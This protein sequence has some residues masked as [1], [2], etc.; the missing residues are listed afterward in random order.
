MPPKALAS[1]VKVGERLALFSYYRVD[2]VDGSFVNVTDEDGNQVRVGREIVDS[3]M[4][5]TTQFA[6]TTKVGQTRMAQIIEGLGQLP[7]CVCF[8]KKV[9][10]NA[11]ADGLDGADLSSQAKRRKLLKTLM[12]GE[13]RVMH[14]R[15]HRSTEDDVEMEL[16]RYKV[17]DLEAS[18]PGKPA[19]RL[20]D[21]RTVKWLIVDGVKFTV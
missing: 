15:L 2:S 6:K 13:E 5:S 9:D 11:V 19:Q 8:A 18:T 20:V 3:S 21:T 16:G 10:P 7:F 1:E 17:V 12:E 14:C 4:V